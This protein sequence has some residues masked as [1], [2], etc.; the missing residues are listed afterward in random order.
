MNLSRLFF[1]RSD[2]AE[3]ERKIFRQHRPHR[4]L[5][6]R[7]AE[8][9]GQ[10]V[11]DRAIV[12]R[13]IAA[14]QKS[15]SMDFYGSD[16][17]WTLFFE[18]H[19]RAQHDAFMKGDVDQVAPILRNPKDSKLFWGFDDLT[20]F[21]YEK[22][23]KT[24]AAADKNTRVS[25]DYFLRLG[26]ALGALALPNPENPSFSEGRGI[27]PDTV[28]EAVD[29]RLGFDMTEPDVYPGRLGIET[30][31]GIVSYRG[32]QAAY[33]IHRILVLLED[34]LGIARPSEASVCEIGAGLGRTALYAHRV[35]LTDYTIVDLPFTAISQGY[36]LMRCL[37]AE[38]VVLA[39]EGD[40]RPDQIKLRHPA[41]FMA[42]TRSFDLV[43]NI[44]SLTEFGEEGAKRYLAQIQQATSLLLSVNHEANP[45]RVQDLAR[46][47]EG[48]VR[49]R[50]HPYWMRPGY[51]EEC[52]RFG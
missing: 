39:G 6:V 18:T 42:S 48:R 27:S 34:E 23:T 52:V 40:G 25:Q 21:Y 29:E 28:L 3:S 43:A 11:D 44:D 32:I 2:P 19:H 45:I 10:R 20:D 41:E 47:L 7:T 17:M 24:P 15:A 51:V 22:W 5:A 31:R 13:L 16:S 49:I 38:A 36:Y 33:A 26:E 9:A 30:G 46:D 1:W 4:G 14:Y 35:G 12:E 37:G 50:R 8:G